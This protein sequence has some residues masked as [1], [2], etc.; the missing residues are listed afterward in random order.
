M[1]CCVMIQA[2][3]EFEHCDGSRAVDLLLIRVDGLATVTGPS[4]LNDDGS[5]QALPRGSYEQARA[6]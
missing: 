3:S 2:D 5:P 6:R 4:Y 1:A